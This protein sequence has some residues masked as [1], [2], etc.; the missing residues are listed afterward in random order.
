MTGETKGTLD[1]QVEI[2][3]MFKLSPWILVE[4]PEVPF[5]AKVLLALI[6]KKR[7]NS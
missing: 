3:K 2:L 1:Q 5:M 7:R 6:Q 4:A